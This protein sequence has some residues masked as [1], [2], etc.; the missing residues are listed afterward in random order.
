MKKRGLPAMAA[1]LMELDKE[2][3]A[4]ITELQSLQQKRN[5]ASREVAE[6]KKKGGDAEAK[7]AEVSAIKQ[8]MVD[9]EE[10]TKKLTEELND[11]LCRIPNRP[12]DD[13]PVGADDEANVEVRRHGEPSKFAFEAKEHD[14]LGS[15]LGMMDFD[16][17]AKLSGARFVILKGA[18]AKLERALAQFML[19]LHT[20][21]H[22]YMEV[23]TPVL[24]KDNALYGTGQL[25]KF[26]EDLFKVGEDFWL[27]PTA[28]VTLTNMASGE[29]IEEE[30][31]PLR[32]TAF[33][34]CFRSEAGAA[35]K[36][37]RGM[38][39]QHQF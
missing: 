1:S 38:I 31:L 19:D 26:S 21:E 6:I 4:K 11:K 37:T 15:A 24:V 18:L 29:I 14:A 3:R 10:A 32:Y 5:E 12:A 2:A 8:A 34:N 28:E 27:I 39:R 30:K 17:A 13:V 20:E 7:I 25:P 33:T 23:N 9:N 36:D 22:G 35:G 16:N